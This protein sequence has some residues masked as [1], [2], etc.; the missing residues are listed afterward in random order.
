MFVCLKAE[1]ESDVK[2]DSPQRPTDHS[3][4]FQLKSRYH[5]GHVDDRHV[6]ALHKIQN[7]HQIRFRIELITHWAFNVWLHR[8]YKLFALTDSHFFNKT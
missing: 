5:H 6:R 4:R 1:K 7:F 2:V 3:P 8:Y